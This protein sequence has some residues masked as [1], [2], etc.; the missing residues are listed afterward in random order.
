[1][2]LATVMRPEIA[3]TSVSLSLDF[4]SCGIMKEAKGAIARVAALRFYIN[5]RCHAL[6][7]SMCVERSEEV[8]SASKIPVMSAYE[9]ESCGRRDVRDNRVIPTAVCCRDYVCMY[10]CVCVRACV[11]GVC[12]YDVC[13]YKHS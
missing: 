7:A 3:I 10:M 12:M 13:M 9:E 6:I 5:P 1:M 8:E 2:L 4:G 11:C